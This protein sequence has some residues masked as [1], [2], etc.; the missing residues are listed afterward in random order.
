MASYRDRRNPEAVHFPG[1]LTTKIMATVGL[2]IC[3]LLAILAITSPEKH[4]MWLLDT[5]LLSV[6]VLLLVWTWPA[7]IITDQ[8][9]I[10]TRRFLGLLSSHISWHEVGRITTV[11]EFGG[12]GARLGLGAEC[13]VVAARTGTVTI[14]HSPRHP[15][16]RRFLLELKQHGVNL[17]SLSDA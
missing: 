13:L 9:G 8:H 5:V 6:V 3:L 12:L 10:R 15:D 2:F 16:R 7:E 1:S 4:W 14:V 11:Q 17:G